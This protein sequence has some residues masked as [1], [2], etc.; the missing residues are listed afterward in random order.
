MLFLRYI[1]CYLMALVVTR[2]PLI[3][4]LLMALLHKNISS[5]NIQTN[6]MLI[7][8]SQLGVRMITSN[9]LDSI[10]SRLSGV[11]TD[12]NSHSM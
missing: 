6:S 4:Y 3:L 1:L 2:Y 9:I 8:E 5:E 10:D 12:F 7:H 11:T